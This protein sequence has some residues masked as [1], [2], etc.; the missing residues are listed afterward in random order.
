[1][2]MLNGKNLFLVSDGGSSSRSVSTVQYSTVQY[3]VAKNICLSAVCQYE[4]KYM[5]C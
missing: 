4:P 5:E 1:L 3:I 2:L